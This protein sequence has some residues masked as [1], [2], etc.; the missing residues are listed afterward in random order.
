MPHIQFRL[1]Q[2]SITL[3]LAQFNR[4]CSVGRRR[5]VCWVAGRPVTM[6]V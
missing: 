2:R 5:E 1:E 4:K 3:L 6:H